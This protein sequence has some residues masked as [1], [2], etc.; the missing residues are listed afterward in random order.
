LSGD[1]Y[2]RID[3][4]MDFGSEFS[5][6]LWVKPDSSALGIQTLVAN[7]PGGWDSEG[8]KLY[9][10]TW[11]DPATADGAVLLET[12]DG[13]NFGLP[14][15]AIRT[16]PDTVFDDVWYHVGATVDMEN[17]IAQIY[18]DGELQSASGGLNI[19]MKT[20][21]PFEIGRMLNDWDLHGIID[22]VQIYDGIL[23]DDEIVALFQNPGSAIG[24]DP[25]T[26][27]DY[28]DDGLVNLADINLQAE[29]MN[30]GSPDLA[31]FDE[32]GDGVVNLADRTIWVRDH[33]GTWIGDANLDGEFNS[34][35]FVSVFT[36]GKYET[37]QPAGWQEGDWNGDQVFG[38]GD[39][40][41]AFT[42]GGY[43]AGQRMAVSAVP[44]PTSILLPGLILTGILMRR[45][46]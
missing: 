16:A 41:T 27:G 40:V 10:H 11:S 39:F 44:E 17:A 25:S 45:R 43:E 6:F 1:Q 28:N 36:V 24:F 8:F 42:D 19:D 32:N 20:D 18:V 3:E 34:G 46:S 30:Q 29:A 23:S 5:V 38:S 22:D 33:A 2:V 37:G 15:D 14:G 4:D 13:V 31:V 35:D 7:A 12:G 26:P 21:G 9:Y